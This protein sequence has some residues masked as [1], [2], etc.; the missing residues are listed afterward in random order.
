MIVFQEICAETF[1]PCFYSIFER[2]ELMIDP[3]SILLDHSFFVK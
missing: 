1:I 2:R 3:D